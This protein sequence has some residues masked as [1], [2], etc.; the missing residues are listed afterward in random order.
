M[1]IWQASVSLETCATN[2]RDRCTD[3]RK[4]GNIV[5]GCQESVRTSIAC[6]TSYE[7]P[8]AVTAQLHKS[9][10]AITKPN[11]HSFCTAT[12]LRA[13]ILR[14]MCSDWFTSELSHQ[15]PVES[16]THQLEHFR[17]ACRLLARILEPCDGPCTVASY[18]RLLLVAFGQPENLGGSRALHEAHDLALGFPG[19][20]LTNSHSRNPPHPS[21]R[22]GL[23]QGLLQDRNVNRQAAI[24]AVADAVQDVV[25]G[26]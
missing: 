4:A 23:V 6:S 12:M 1:S 15:P 14:C 16:L 5:I 21:V 13:S 19:L 24:L 11:R 3:R 22:V 10:P 26:F 17:S 25:A 9:G 20:W 7:S 2:K 18:V 8:G